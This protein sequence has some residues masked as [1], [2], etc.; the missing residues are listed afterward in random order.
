[1]VVHPSILCLDARVYPPS[2]ART[3][4]VAAAHILPRRF[5][6][7]GVSALYQPATP[8][9]SFAPAPA[10]PTFIGISA[11]SSTLRHLLE[12]GDG[13]PQL[14]SFTFCVA[15]ASFLCG[16]SKPGPR[17]FLNLEIA[18]Q[19]QWVARVFPAW[20]LIVAGAPLSTV[21][22]ASHI[23][24]SYLTIPVIAPRDVGGGRCFRW[25]A[26]AFEESFGVAAGIYLCVSSPVTRVI[27]ASYHDR[28]RLNANLCSRMAAFHRKQP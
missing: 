19:R 3:R 20:F 17:W 5:S 22:V 13:T 27:H 10:A 4:Y 9:V 18:R 16:F 26:G 24:E 7:F 14:S 15:V 11:W 23:D 8:H 28:S 25:R 12:I 6:L 2:P 1:M 21:L